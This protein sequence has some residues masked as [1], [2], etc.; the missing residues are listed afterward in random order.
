MCVCVCDREKECACVCVTGKKSVCG[1]LLCV[2]VRV[3]HV[4]I[5]YFMQGDYTQFAFTD[6]VLMH[7]PYCDRERNTLFAIS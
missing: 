3:R 4:C 2:C 1:Y 6:F 5:L 7:V